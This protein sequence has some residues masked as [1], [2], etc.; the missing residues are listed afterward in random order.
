MCL[1]AFL[2]TSDREPGTIFLCV[3]ESFEKPIIVRRWYRTDEKE[4]GIE[5]T[6]NSDGSWMLASGKT[7]YPSTICFVEHQRIRK[8]KTL[9]PCRWRDGGWQLLCKKGWVTR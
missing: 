1:T 8:P 4:A 2:T 7:I 5:A 3:T 6:P 9:R